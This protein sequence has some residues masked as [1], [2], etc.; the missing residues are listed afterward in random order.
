MTALSTFDTHRKND[1]KPPKGTS[2]LTDRSS[3]GL[4]AFASSFVIS[5]ARLPS[6]YCAHAHLKV[7]M[8]QSLERFLAG[9]H[10]TSRQGGCMI[11]DCVAIPRKV[12]RRFPRCLYGAVQSRVE[13]DVAIPRKV[14]RRFPRVANAGNKQSD[15]CRNPSKGSSPVSTPMPSWSHWSIVSVAIP[16]KVPRRFPPQVEDAQHHQLCT[17]R[18]PSKGS[19]PVSTHDYDRN[20]DPACEV[21]IPRKV[22]RRFPRRRHH[23]HF[24]VPRNV[25]IPRKVPRRFPQGDS[26]DQEHPRFRVAIPRKVPRRFPPRGR[27]K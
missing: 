26:D 5:S 18:N 2:V 12:P 6:N 14:P 13:V 8:S 23:V 17:C 11:F 24:E 3:M 7:P 20:R 22:P 4:R 9:F 16:R 21:A 1:A 25:A 19:S 27:K 10:M 15:D